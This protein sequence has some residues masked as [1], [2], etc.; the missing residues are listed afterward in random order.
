MFPPTFGENPSKDEQMDTTCARGK[1]GGHPYVLS[2]FGETPS[3]DERTP[4]HALARARAL[5]HAR[6]EHEQKKY[7]A[8]AT[9][10]DS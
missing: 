1:H 5:A 3:K 9:C 7:I 4:N 2:K 8:H 10:G 6:A